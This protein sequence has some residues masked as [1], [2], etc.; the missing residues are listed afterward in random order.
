MA[1]G[2]D[3]GPEVYLVSISI[4]SKTLVVHV[5]IRA[6]A[7]VDRKEDYYLNL[8]FAFPHHEDPT[9][10]HSNTIIDGELVIDVDPRTG[11]VSPLPNTR[12][13]SN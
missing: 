2:T 10:V 13:N 7:Q 12:R 1:L 9:A 4:N 11:Q 5:D 8:G 6:T 3:A